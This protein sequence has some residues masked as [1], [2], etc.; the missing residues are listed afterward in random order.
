VKPARR[1]WSGSW[2]S[3]ASSSSSEGY[4]PGGL[5]QQEP[6]EVGPVGE[7]ERADLA[8]QRRRQGAHLPD[9]G[10][11]ERV[12]LGLGQHVQAE[13]QLEQRRVGEGHALGGGG[14]AEADGHGSN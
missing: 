4:S 14:Q 9:P 8:P 2:L 10:L 11:L 1:A 13:D 7:R 6:R 12:V 5:G 3:R